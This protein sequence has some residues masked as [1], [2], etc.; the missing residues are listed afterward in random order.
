MLLFF[1]HGIATRDAQY[2]KQLKAFIRQGFNN[3][4]KTV[5]HFYASVWGIF[6]VIQRKCGAGDGHTRYWNCRQMAYLIMA[7]ILGE[8]GHIHLGEDNAIDTVKLIA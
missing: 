6:Q 4:G 7:N 3:R 1:I 5:P 8:P 2:A